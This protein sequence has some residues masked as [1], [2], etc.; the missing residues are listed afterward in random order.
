MS[1]PEP[2]NDFRLPGPAAQEADPEPFLLRGDPAVD[3][4]SEAV[5]EPAAVERTDRRAAPRS[6]ESEMAVEPILPA[7]GQ[8]GLL[9]VLL[10]LA[11]LLAG[12]WYLAQPTTLPIRQVGIEGEFRQLS[13][14]ELQQLISGQLRGGFFSM[15]VTALRNAV[16]ANPWV[17]DVQVQRVWP[18]TLKVMVREQTAVAQWHDR[19]LVN[20]SGEYFEPDMTSAPA[21]LPVLVGPP[22]SQMLLTERLLRL[23][24]ALAPIGLEVEG[25]TLSDRRAWTFTTTGGLEVV[26]GR[27]EFPSRLQRFVELVPA[28]LGERFDAARYVDMRY[29]NGFAVRFAEDDGPPAAGPIEGNGAA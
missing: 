18:D 13:R 5:T 24:E 9:A 15:D 7:A 8:R 14:S 17:R 27:E 16:T 4:D 20:T 3:D 28:S 1:T 21:G 11:G 29:T 23:Q 2:L 10:L 26:L 22:D 25:L 6:E 12:G 19:G